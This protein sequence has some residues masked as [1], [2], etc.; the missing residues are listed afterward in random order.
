[1]K[2]LKIPS[3]LIVLAITLAGTACDNNSAGPG[4]GSAAVEGQVQ[5][6]NTQNKAKYS[7]PTTAAAVEGATVTAARISSD[8]SLET[9]SGAETE[10]NAEG[11]FT[12]NINAE[13]VANSGQQVIIMAEKSGQQW[14]TFITGELES[15]STVQVQPLTVE[16]SGEADVYSKIVAEG[17]AEMVSKA[18]IEAYIGA[19]ASSAIQSNSQAAATYAE[20]L[21]AEA[22][23]RAEFFASQSAE[24]TG[25]Q[26]QQIM[27]T[28][29]QAQLQLESELNAAT[30]AE[31]E[32]A[33]MEAFTKTV[34]KAHADA[35]VDA[36]L[37]AKA[38]EMSNRVFV[39]HSSEVSAEAESEARTTAALFTS[40]AI[41]AAVQARME[42]QGATE[43]NIQAAADAAVTLRSD[44]KAMTG[45]T[46]EDIDA[47][48]ETYNEA[49][50][51]ALSQE[52]SANAQTMTEINARINED[53]GAKAELESSLEATLSL[54]IFVDAYT[55]FYSEVKTI[56]DESFTTA[57]DAEAEFVA[58]IMVLANL[59]N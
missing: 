12:L 6:E 8:G 33:A 55:T 17:N 28:K 37:Y 18:D 10:T 49:V 5:D 19:K 35:G 48:F 25:D 16:S 50:V 40:Y 24:I 14:K 13:A 26:K 47:A 46:K 56:V 52:F 29:T 57:N 36:E 23:A 27:E 22:E 31:D 42:A 53:N 51:N 32:Q 58:D 15:G 34:V 7:S 59:G 54:Q 4:E 45:A 38:K 43:S 39:K 3:L 11:E 41:D 21:A 30:S 1:M 20:A 44:I 9:I 2:H